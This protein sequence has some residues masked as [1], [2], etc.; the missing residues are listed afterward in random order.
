MVPLTFCHPAPVTRRIRSRTSCLLKAITIPSTN[1]T[2]RASD[3]GVLEII[4]DTYCTRFRSTFP[5]ARFCRARDSGFSGFFTFLDDPE[6]G[7]KAVRPDEVPGLLPDCRSVD[8]VPLPFEVRFD[9][10]FSRLPLRL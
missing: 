4:R 2:R 8:L 7:E 1:H 5:T 3:R 10:F 6:G 9:G